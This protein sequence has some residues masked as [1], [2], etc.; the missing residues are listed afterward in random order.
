MAWHD[1]KIKN[2]EQIKVNRLFYFLF[3]KQPPCTGD[4]VVE[5][6]GW[7]DKGDEEER[8]VKGGEDER[9]GRGG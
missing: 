3:F 6:D 5:Q 9:G 1:Q 4:E 8:R 7:M 2:W